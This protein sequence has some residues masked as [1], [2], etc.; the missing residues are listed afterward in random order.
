MTLA[1]LVLM[2]EF[3]LIYRASYI[4]TF[5]QRNFFQ[6]AKDSLIEL[7]LGLKMILKK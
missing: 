3:W 2:V 7:R 6:A 1:F 4:K 5:E